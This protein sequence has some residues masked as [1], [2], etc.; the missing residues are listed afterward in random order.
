MDDETGCALSWS[1]DGGKVGG[2]TDI[3][4]GSAAIQRELDRLEKGE[5]RNLLKSKR[6]DVQSPAIGVKQDWH[7]LKSSVLEKDLG[8]HMAM[9]INQ[10]C[11]LAVKRTLH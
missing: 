2:V 5:D 11:V 8:F 3:P 1:A 6:G 10:Q 9:N 4:E 7:Q